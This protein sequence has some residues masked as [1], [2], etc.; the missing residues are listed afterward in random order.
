MGRI[1]ESESRGLLAGGEYQSVPQDMGGQADDDY[2]Y[3]RRANWRDRVRSRV[4]GLDRRT[5]KLVALGVV[6]LFVTVGFLVSSVVRVK[7]EVS[8]HVSL[9]VTPLPL[10]PR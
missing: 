2:T 10:T 5:C 9:L 3:T 1:S 4:S 8:T 6:L 7:D